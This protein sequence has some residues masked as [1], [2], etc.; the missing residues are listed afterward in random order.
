MEWNLWDPVFDKATEENYSDIQGSQ[1]T[2]DYGYGPDPIKEDNKNWESVMQVLEIW[3][4]KADKDLLELEEDLLKLHAQLYMSDKDWS[5]FCASILKEKIK[6]FEVSIERLKHGSI[7]LQDDGDIEHPREPAESLC[8]L[9]TA[10]LSSYCQQKVDE[11][12]LQIVAY[13]S[14]SEHSAHANNG[15]IQD[16]TDSFFEPETAI[17]EYSSPSPK[18]MLINI[19]ECSNLRPF[20]SVEGGPFFSEPVEP[21]TAMVVYSSPSPTSAF[22]SKKRKS[23]GSRKNE[24][25]GS[26]ISLASTAGEGSWLTEHHLAADTASNSLK[27]PLLPVVVDYLSLAELRAMG[28]R[29]KLK[30]WYKLKKAELARQLGLDMHE[31]RSKDKRRGTIQWIQDIYEV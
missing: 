26:D 2:F 14:S 17:V 3:I 9:L 24:L 21:E 15:E 4:T 25:K 12:S 31:G 27:L 28:K 11:Q 16:A 7:Q 5:K 30:G 22:Q 13:E 8:D 6:Y 20:F 19:D 23:N 1:C 29:Q 10:L 18:R